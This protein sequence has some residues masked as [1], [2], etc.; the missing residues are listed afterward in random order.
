MNIKQKNDSSK[1]DLIM[2]QNVLEINKVKKGE[3]TSKEKLKIIEVLKF[4][5]T[6]LN[7][8]GYRKAIKYDPRNFYQYYLSLLFTKHNLFKIFNTNDY[9]AYSIKVLL[10]FFNFSSC[11]AV[12]ALFFNDN[13]MHQIYEDEGDFNFIYQLPQIAYSTLISYFIDS[14]TSF[15][16]LSE[17]N[18][19]ELKKDKNLVYIN[20]KGRN[21]KNILKVKFLFFFIVNLILILVLGY[22]L[23]CF[24]AVYKNTQFHVIKDTLIS[25]G[26]GFIIPLGTNMLTDLIRIYSLREYTNGNRML[27][28][29]SRLLQQYL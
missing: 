9:N 25:F 8:L 13:T 15:L 16:A 6:E 17:D 29:L 22:Y 14:L 12:N 18:I 23:C 1:Q 26:I 10:L 20:E 2:G 21:V 11:Y 28:G 7:E 5:D 27:Y 4:N 19:I 3:F 24:C